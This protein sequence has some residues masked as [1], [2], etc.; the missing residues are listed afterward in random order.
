MRDKIARSIA[1]VFGAGY[2]PL[3][4][5]TFGSIAG[6]LVYLYIKANLTVYIGTIVIATILGFI[7]SRMA[8]RLFYYDDPGE[9]VIDEFC[10][11]LIT[12]MFIPPTAP[13][14]VAGFFLFRIID[15]LKVPPLGRLE[16][17]KGG[18]GIMLDDI[19]AG[20]IA[21]VILRVI[22]IIF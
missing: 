15:I 10:G 8:K 2:L 1:T 9:V 13:N 18:A 16:R 19:G 3:M 20:V 12:Y 4:P 14:I 21:N 22:N 11:M 5:G 6:L 7:V 17:V